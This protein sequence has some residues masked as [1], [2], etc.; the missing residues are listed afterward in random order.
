MLKPKIIKLPDYNDYVG[1]EFIVTKGGSW[2]ELVNFPSEEEYQSLSEDEQDEIDEKFEYILPYNIYAG[3]KFKITKIKKNI[4][5]IKIV[6]P[7]EDCKKSIDDIIARLSDSTREEIEIFDTIIKWWNDE[8]H[9][10]EIDENS[11]WNRN[12]YGDERGHCINTGYR[13]IPA[14]HPDKYG[15]AKPRYDKDTGEYINDD[16][17]MTLDYRRTDGRLNIYSYQS[18]SNT[19][20]SKAT[21]EF[22][23]LA[24]LQTLEKYESGKGGNDFFK[25]WLSKG[26]EI[27]I[28]F[29]NALEFDMI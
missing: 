1:K 24:E 17:I 19:F 11:P 4:A 7:I 8:P 13:G 21:Y 27:R 12:S 9:L 26:M 6:S 20:Y 23:R 14:D 2:E 5:T 28:E 18:E 22:M 10:F 16:T 29:L 25:S 15:M 3:M